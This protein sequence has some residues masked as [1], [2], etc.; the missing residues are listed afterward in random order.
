MRD[1]RVE[2]RVG[3]ILKRLKSFYR[4]IQVEPWPSE[5]KPGNVRVVA[6]RTLRLPG[7]RVQRCTHTD[8]DWWR[9][10]MAHAE[11]IHAAEEEAPRARP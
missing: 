5:R 1:P 3:D 8:L 6:A 4:V 2:P 11:V 7:P 9:R 10:D